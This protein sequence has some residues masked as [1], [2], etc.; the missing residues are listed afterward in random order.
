MTQTNNIFS[1]PTQLRSLKAGRGDLYDIDYLKG[2][3]GP[4]NAV[5]ASSVVSSKYNFVST[6]VILDA[7]KPMGFGVS[8]YDRQRVK[9]NSDDRYGFEKHMIRKRFVT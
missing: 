8:S 5:K 9:T 7:L 1:Q 3:A 6:E 2:Y 4:H